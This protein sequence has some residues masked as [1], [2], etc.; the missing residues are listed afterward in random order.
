M[1]TIFIF[2][3]SGCKLLEVA[4]SDIGGWDVSACVSGF[5]TCWELFRDNSNKFEG[6][7]VDALNGLP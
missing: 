5:S 2:S 6:G 4:V 1:F 7:F 3:S